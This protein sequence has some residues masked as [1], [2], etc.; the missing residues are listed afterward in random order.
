M[1]EKNI[2]QGFRFKKQT[3]QEIISFEE[4]EQNE[5]MSR[6]QKKVGT[7]V[8]YIEQFFILASAVTRC[9]SISALLL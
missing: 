1:K 6:K 4:N 2:S 8:N 5:L 9:I 3:K 7:T